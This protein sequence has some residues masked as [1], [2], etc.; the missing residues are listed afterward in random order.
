MHQQIEQHRTQHFNTLK[1]I[2][3]KT[4]SPTAADANA[5]ISVFDPAKVNA[6]NQYTRIGDAMSRTFVIGDDGVLHQQ[7]FAAAT[8][9]SALQQHQPSSS[10]KASSA[11]SAIASP[12]KTLNL[13]GTRPLTMTTNGVFVNTVGGGDD[14]VV[15][16]SRRAKTADATTLITSPHMYKK[17]PTLKVKGAFFKQGLL[18]LVSKSFGHFPVHLI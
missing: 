11:L 5:G 15:D 2:R 6:M 12:I 14:A 9:S 7:T 16:E 18:I 1:A 10:P 13:N 8:A 3:T 17:L 4:G